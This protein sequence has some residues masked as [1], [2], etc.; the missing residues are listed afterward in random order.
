VPASPSSRFGD[1][2]ILS[3]TAPDGRQRHVVAL[4]LKPEALVHLT[5]Y[6]VREGDAIDLLAARL[7]GDEGL[8]W[9]LLDGNPIRYP[10]DLV[11]GDLLEVAGLTS[12]TVGTRA[13]TF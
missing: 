6:R 12:V 5:T 9:R 10:L 1:L 7:Y 2:P 13:R 4:R 8:W 11:A 3:V